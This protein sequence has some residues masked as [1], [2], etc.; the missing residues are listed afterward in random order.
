MGKK[1]LFKGNSGIGGINTSVRLY[2]NKRASHC[3]HTIVIQTASPSVSQNHLTFSINDREVI[4][5]SYPVA[6]INKTDILKSFAYKINLPSTDAIENGYSNYVYTIQMNGSFT[7]FKLNPNGVISNDIDAANSYFFNT[8]F[9]HD[10]TW[11][12]R[13][14]PTISS[15]VPYKAKCY[16]TASAGVSEP[17]TTVEIFN[18]ADGEYYIYIKIT[19]KPQTYVVGTLKMIYGDIY[20]ATLTNFYENFTFNVAKLSM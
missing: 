3:K 7:E 10:T 11:N 1:I 8:H 19:L 17:D 9:V 18:N 6:L 12:P 5:S 20:P 4:E 16:N 14:I 2:K 15:S 13:I